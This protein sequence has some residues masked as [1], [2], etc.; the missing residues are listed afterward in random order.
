MKILFATDGSA[1]A[2]AALI[3][4]LDWFRDHTA[5]KRVGEPAPTLLR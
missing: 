2:L 4:H 1:R 3:G 5:A